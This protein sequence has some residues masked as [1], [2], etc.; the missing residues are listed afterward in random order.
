[1]PTPA[2][3]YYLPGGAN[4]NARRRK[5]ANLIPATAWNRECRF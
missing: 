3:A 2:P 5:A 1:L 4:K